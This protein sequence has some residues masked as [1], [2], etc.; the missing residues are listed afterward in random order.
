M[1][2]FWKYLLKANSGYDGIDL[3]SVCE[4]VFGLAAERFLESGAETGFLGILG[5]EF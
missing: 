3:K 5:E 4:V 2:F 1:I